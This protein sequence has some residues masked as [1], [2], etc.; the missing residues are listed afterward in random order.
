MQFSKIDTV[1]NKKFGYFFS[2]L[3]TLIAMYFFIYNLKTWAYFFTTITIIFFVLTLVKAELL[4]TLNKAWMSLGF[5]LGK[6][7]NP[8]IMGIIFFCI[9][10][11]ISIVMRLKGRDVLKIRSKKK[12]SHWILRDKSFIKTKFKQQF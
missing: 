4:L 5:M 1:S 9:F 6:V 12:T 8:I 2:F 7:F 11:P 3:F 10:S